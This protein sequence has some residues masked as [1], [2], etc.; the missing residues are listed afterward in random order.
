MKT[1][2]CNN[3]KKRKLLIEFHKDRTKKD[4]LHTF[5]K[6]CRNKKRKEYVINNKDLIY[7]KRTDYYKKY[8]WMNS[9]RALRQRCLNPKDSVYI[10]YGAKGILPIITKDEIKYLWFRDKA[11]L[12]K[13]PS[14]DREET[15]GNYELS[16]C[17]F[18][19]HKENSA[20]ANRKSI[21]QYNLNG[22]FIK[23]WKSITE[24][25]IFFNICESTLC[26]CLKK[27]QKTSCGFI[28]KYK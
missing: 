6:I 25:V 16:N 5:C 4:S 10:Y 27:R 15:D 19:E 18:I 23:E 1:K 21:L 3:C 2:I 8:P 11:Y 28:W 7:K 17:S 26:G 9:Y 24:A 20:K 22:K 13:K 12:M 14:I